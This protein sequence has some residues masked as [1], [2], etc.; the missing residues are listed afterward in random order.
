[1]KGAVVL[2][3]ENLAIGI[4]TGGEE[5]ICRFEIATKRG[6]VEQARFLDQFRGCSQKLSQ[7]GSIPG[8]GREGLFDLRGRFQAGD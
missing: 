6:L 1:M 5:K 2:M 4:T 8:S 7:G 3:A